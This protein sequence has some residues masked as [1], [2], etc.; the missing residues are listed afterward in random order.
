MTE[1]SR[2]LHQKALGAGVSSAESRGTHRQISKTVTS[3]CDIEENVRMTD[4]LWGFLRGLKSTRIT[5]MRNLVP[6]I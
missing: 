2:G 4:D 3:K 5:D 6:M 1:T